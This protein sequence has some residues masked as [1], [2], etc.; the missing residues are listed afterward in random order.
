M[1]K[2]SLTFNGGEVYRLNYHSCQNPRSIVPIIFPQVPNLEYWAPESLRE[3]F[4]GSLEIF[5]ELCREII[6]QVDQDLKKKPAS[7]DRRNAVKNLKSQTGTFRRLINNYLKTLPGLDHERLLV[8]FYNFSLACDS[9]G[10]LR[11]FGLASSE[12]DRLRHIP[13]NPEKV[14]IRK[15]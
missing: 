10:H 14:S 8:Q 11:G 6:A 15:T 7:W 12:K 5:A 13:L 4:V 3:F 9:L 1:E 2:L